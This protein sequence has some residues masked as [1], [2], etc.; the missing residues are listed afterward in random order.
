[1]DVNR[2]FGNSFDDK[3]KATVGS[4][5]K[6]Q[7]ITIGDKSISMQLWDTAGGEKHMS[8]QSLFFRGSHACALVFDL[9]NRHSFQEILE[10]KKLL[11]EDKEIL[12]PSKFPFILI[13]NKSDLS[14]ERKVI[15]FFMYRF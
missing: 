10:W 1:M 11:L 2:I 4:D 14:G 9:T 6:S 5:T 7:E 13:G 12:N 3:Y 8:F 15:A